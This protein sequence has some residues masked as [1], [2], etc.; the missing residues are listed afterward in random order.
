MTQELSVMQNHALP[1]IIGTT[2]EKLPTKSG[3]MYIGNQKRIVSFTYIFFCSKA[4]L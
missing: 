4:I 1:E 3:P 2:D